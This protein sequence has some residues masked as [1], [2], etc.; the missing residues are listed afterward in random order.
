MLHKT[1]SLSQN[2]AGCGTVVGRDADA[3]AAREHFPELGPEAVVQPGVEEGVAAGRAHGTQVTEQLNEQEVAL[4]NQVNVDV[5]QHVEHADGHPADAEGRHHQA[6]QP[7]GLA[8]AHALSLDLALGVVAGDHAVP[9]LDRDAQVGDGERR[10][11]QDV[12]DEQGAVRVSQPLLLLAHPELFTDG[13]A[14]ILELHMVGVSYSRSHQ[15]AG[16]QPDPRQKVGAGQDSDA[17]FQRVNGGIIP[18]KKQRKA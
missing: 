1:Q 17:L 3:T 12:C 18:A 14:F 8:F 10:Q 9:Q 7:E 13:E 2:H 15:T 6:H 4:V 5:A 11:R 16:Q